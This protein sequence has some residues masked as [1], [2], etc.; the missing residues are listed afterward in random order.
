M[1]TGSVSLNG[2]FV[3][4]N[5]RTGENKIAEKRTVKNTVEERVEL[6]TK[7]LPPASQEE[8]MELVR[9]ID[10]AQ[11]RSTNWLSKNG[12]TQLSQLLES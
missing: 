4:Q 12:A 7:N 10:F 1:K 3:N 8:I 6:S 11:M 9:K 5:K 2:V